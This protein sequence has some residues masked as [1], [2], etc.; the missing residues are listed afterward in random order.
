MQHPLREVEPSERDAAAHM[1][2]ALPPHPQLCGKEFVI[3]S[4]P[5]NHGKPGKGEYP[6][7]VFVWCLQEEG[8]TAPGQLLDT[9][10]PTSAQ[11]NRA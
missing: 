4:L 1:V 10:C 2:L 11:L 8:C 7:R 3:S 6:Q 5:A 9:V